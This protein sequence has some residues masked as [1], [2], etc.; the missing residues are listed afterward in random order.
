MHSEKQQEKVLWVSRAAPKAYAFEK[1]F[2]YKKGKNTTSSHISTANDGKYT[3]NHVYVIYS[4][5][6]FKHFYTRQGFIFFYYLIV[7]IMTAEI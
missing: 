7:F 3:H 6:I 2:N 1:T 4:A 5:T